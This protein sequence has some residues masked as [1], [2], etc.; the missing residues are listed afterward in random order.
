VVVGEIAKMKI[1]TFR[2]SWKKMRLLDAADGAL[3]I[4]YMPPLILK[5]FFMPVSK[6]VVVHFKQPCGATFITL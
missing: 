2:I 3:K 1:E 5:Q 4:Y 6:G